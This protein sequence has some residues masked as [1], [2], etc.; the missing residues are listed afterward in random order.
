MINNSIYNNKKEIK[1]A[2]AGNPNS[3]KTTLFNALTGGN[4]QVGNWPGVTVEKKTGKCVFRSDITVTD[5]PGC[6]SLSPFTPEE[7]VACDYLNGGETDVVLNV[8]D[9]TNVERNLLLTTQLLELGLPVVVA[10]NMQDEA[11]A[12]GIEIDA[13]KMSEQFGCP[14]VAVSAAKGEGLQQLANACAEAANKPVARKKLHFESANDRYTA[15]ERAL[16][17]AVQVKKSP[18]ELSDKIDRVLLNKWAAFPIFTVVLTGIFFLSA[19]CGGKLTDMMEQFL[20][21]ALQSGVKNV[22]WSAPEWLTSLL[23][24]GVIGGV[25]SV[26]GFVPQV[27]ILYGCIAALEACGYMARIAFITDRLLH[28][29]GLGGRSFVCLILGCGCSVPAIMSARTIKNSAERETTITLAPLVPC[30]AK[31]AVIAFFTSYMFDGNALYAVSFYFASVIAVVIGGLTLKLFRREKSENDNVFLLELPPYRM[32]QF[33]NVL[34]QM[35]ERG[36][37][38]LI[39]AGTVILAAS[40]LLWTLTNFDFRFAL[41]NAEHS[42]IADIGRFISPLFRPL[43]FDDGGCGWQFAVATVSGFAAKETVISTLQILLPNGLENAVSPLGAYSFVLYNL[44]TVPCVAACGA[45]F[46]EQGG[47]KKGLKSAALQLTLAYAL[48]FAFYQ[49]GR[50]L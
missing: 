42:M 2:L 23:C 38:F 3:G 15:I 44:F 14:F 36:K 8:V 13:K 29:L 22:L 39:K 34:R 35:W 31:L 48:S 21:P 37:N 18:L 47:W 33:K 9:S 46:A 41:T 5:T 40:V 45:S 43:G 24:D 27:M 17:K 7:R 32:P 4:G 26:A 6:Y 19:G 25:M 11:R 28:G 20:T 16:G 10:L 50:L 49:T 1:V 30:S 12:K